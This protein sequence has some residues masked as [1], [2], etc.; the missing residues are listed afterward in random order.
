MK[1]ISN[2]EIRFFFIVG[3]LALIFFGGLVHRITRDMAIHI[4]EEIGRMT[5]QEAVDEIVRLRAIEAR[6]KAGLKSDVITE[7]Y[8]RMK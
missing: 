5:P 3:L 1:M 8:V 4:P 2:K 6:Y 7:P